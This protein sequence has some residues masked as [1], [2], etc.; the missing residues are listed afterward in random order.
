LWSTQGLPQIVNGTAGFTPRELDTLRAQ[1]AGFPDAPS[2]AAL[3]AIGVRSVLLDTTRVGGTPW[4]DAAA[5]PVDGL[6][7]GRREVGSTVLFDLS[8]PG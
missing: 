6:G 3:R 4:Q 8:G 2:V 7:I 1:T 5:R